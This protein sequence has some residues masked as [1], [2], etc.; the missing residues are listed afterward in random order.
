MKAAFPY[1]L[2][3][4]WFLLAKF[5]LDASNMEAFL[6]ASLFWLCGQ[7]VQLEKKVDR[8]LDHHPPQ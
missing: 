7:H 1:A 5:A 3:L 6:F 8:W 2:A 4:G